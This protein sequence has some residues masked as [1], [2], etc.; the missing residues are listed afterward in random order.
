MAIFITMKKKENEKPVKRK[1][2][3][4]TLEDEENCDESLILKTGNSN[5][6]PKVS[7]ISI[8][9]QR[10]AKN[11]TE[12]RKE[13]WCS[14]HNRHCLKD[15]EPHVEI[16]NMM[17]STWATEMLNGLATLKEPPTHPS[18]AYSSRNRSQPRHTLS[19]VSNDLQNPMGMANPFFSNFFQAL[20]T[21]HL[22]QL[23]S[24]PLTSYNS[25]TPQLSSTQPSMIEFLQQIDEV[26][27]TED[28]YFK[29]LEGFEKQRI[30]VKHLHKLSDKQFEACGITTIGDIETIRDAA[31]KY[32]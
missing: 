2:K 31:K 4:S 9:D 1:K 18:F 23:Q 8:L 14:M 20:F 16:S 21:P 25:M 13:T 29:F 19:Q 24:S 17:F 27:K 28:Y 26:E 11:V 10:I 6:I 30:K 12:L 15:R 32:T 3:D 22:P 5:K 7:D